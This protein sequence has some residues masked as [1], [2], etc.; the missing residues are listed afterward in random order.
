M[1]WEADDWGSCWALEYK[2]K[3]LLSKER[4][5]NDYIANKFE[6]PGGN[7][8]NE[9]HQQALKRELKEELLLGGY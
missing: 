8:D 7:N 1:V 5:Q 4:I 9:T 6:F 2:G 3:L